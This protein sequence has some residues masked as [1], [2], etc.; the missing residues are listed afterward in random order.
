[1][2]ER[3]ILF[4]G[5]MVLAIL[6]GKKTQTRRVVKL[7]N[8]DFEF[9]HEPEFKVIGVNRKI[10][11]KYGQPGDRL[12]VKETWATTEQAGDHAADA[13]PVYRATDPD[14]ETMDGWKWKSPRFMPRS[15]SR[16]LLEIVSVRVERLQE[17][18]DADARSEG[19]TIGSD[20]EIAAHI[21]GEPE[22]AARMEFW[23]LWQSINEDKPGRD[24]DS[25]PW[26]WRIE[27]KRVEPI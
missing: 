12:W 21:A 26:V 15:A 5:P 1:M 27:F 13:H 19:V 24:W 7:D 18:S 16:I 22:T 10:K 2:K 4:S 6:A 14:W 11:C 20:T 8:S 9:Q 25:N 3:P 17:I 23:H